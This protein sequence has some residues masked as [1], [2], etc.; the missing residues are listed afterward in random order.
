[1][2]NA[3]LIEGVWVLQIVD[4]GPKVGKYTSN[5]VDSNGGGHISYYD[6]TNNAPR[7]A[8]GY[9]VTNEYYLPF[10]RHEP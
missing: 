8:T 3:S 1:M 2:K 7:Y 10:I 5:A 6:E 4:Y 9:I